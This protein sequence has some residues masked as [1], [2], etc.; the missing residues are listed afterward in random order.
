MP[1]KLQSKL[2]PRGPAPPH[3]HPQALGLQGAVVPV[4]LPGAARSFVPLAPTLT[5]EDRRVVDN[6][7]KVR[8]I[9]DTNFGGH[10]GTGGVTGWL[11]FCLVGERQPPGH[12]LFNP[13]SRP[14][15]PSLYICPCTRFC[16]HSVS[17]S[18]TP[19]LLTEC[20]LRLRHCCALQIITFLSRGS[21][22]QASPASTASPQQQQQQ[23][24]GLLPVIP[25]SLGDGTA[26]ANQQAVVSEGVAVAG[27]LLPV[28]PAVATE[29]VPQLVGRLASRVAARAV[30]E[31]FV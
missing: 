18:W 8:E 27:E 12:D 30:R 5:E 17:P 9:T 2:Y 26:G 19:A 28:L 7:T 10:Y 31:V 14:C 25:L 6:V 16:R 21:V 29:I 11:P 3:P 13:H 22:G 24:F 1:I 20:S 23:P 4:L 15:A